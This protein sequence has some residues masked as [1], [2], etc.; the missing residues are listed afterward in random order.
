MKKKLDSFSKRLSVAALGSFPKRLLEEGKETLQ[1]VTPALGPDAASK[2]SLHS[3]LL[4]TVI[5]LSLFVKTLIQ[6]RPALLRQILEEDLLGSS[7]SPEKIKEMAEAELLKAQS[8]EEFS[9]RIR[10]FRNRLMLRI[11]IRDMGGLSPFSETCLELSTLACVCLEAV[12]KWLERQM[13]R[14]FGFPQDSKG[15]I[16]RLMVIGMGKLGAGELNFSSDID[17]IFAFRGKGYTS[18]GRKKISNHEY[19]LHQCQKLMAILSRP[20][21]EG[22]VFRVDT[23]LRPFGD[24]GPLVMTTDE[25]LEYYERQGRQWERYALVKAS[26]VAGD[27][28]GGRRLLEEL[29]P[30]VY[31]KYIDYSTIEAL[32]EMKAMIVAEQAERA[33]TNNVKLGPGG[34]RDIEF[35]VQTFQLIKGGRIKALQVQSLI[36]ALE[37]IKRLG[38]LPEETCWDLAKAYVWLRVTENRLQEY[39]DRQVQTLPTDEERR[40]RLALSLGYTD[41]E[42]FLDSYHRHTQKAR[43]V[44]QGLF[45]EEREKVE[46]DEGKKGRSRPEAL[47]VWSSPE[48]PRALSIL[49]GFGFSNSGETARLIRNFKESKKVKSLPGQVQEL[50]DRLVPNL[51]LASASTTDPDKAFSLGISIFEAVLKRSIYLVLLDQNP[52]ALKH[53]VFLCS[54]SRLVGE[55]LRRQPILLDELVS[56]ESLFREIDKEGLRKLLLATLEALTRKDLEHWLDE[57]RRFKKAQVLRIAASQL[58]GVMGVENVGISLTHLAEIIL[59]EVFR[60]AWQD[61]AHKAPVFIHGAKSIQESG[62]AVI[63]YGKLGSRELSYSSDL[64]LVFLYQPETFGPLNQAQ[65][66]ELGYFYSR[67]IQRLLFFLSARTSQGVLYEIDTRLRPNGSQGILVSTVST[68]NEYQLKKAWTWEH[69]ALIKARFI[70]GDAGCGTQFEAI[71]TSVICQERDAKRLKEEII[72]MREKMIK[73]HV[74]RVGEGLFHVKNS[75]GGLVDIEFIAQYLVLRHA[76]KEKRLSDYRDTRG[77]LR[78]LGELGYLTKDDEKCL[79][80]A[81]RQYQE[82][83]SLKALDMEEPVAP[84]EELDDT[85]KGVLETWNKLFS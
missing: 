74:K 26:P 56:S 46:K 29:R 11:A 75:P 25:M 58:K 6:R 50:L 24:S 35:V 66:G 12:L 65:R 63:A 82:L 62:L 37:V 80:L 9:K 14:D 61:M 18:G 21:P 28:E 7:L 31:R 53:L 42:D 5:P 78:A 54:K 17:I 84:L 44:F 3:H 71:R 49:E 13:A 30:F 40:Y 33:G 22:F 27:I 39:H 76:S 52:A 43:T 2:V 72:K 81:H 68:F 55:L 51:L 34:I 79:S 41:W 60:G 48:D 15:E 67:F 8:E 85:R 73:S 47:F 83:V 45:H 57:L 1:E 32:K 20:M 36:D 64:D 23:R 16:L 77:L 69:Q 38:L 70:C 59:E 4:G 19:F 10:L